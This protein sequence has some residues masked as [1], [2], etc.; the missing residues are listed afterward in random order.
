M[1]SVSSLRGKIMCAMDGQT[2][3]RFQVCVAAKHRKSHR[4]WLSPVANWQ[5]NTENLT[6]RR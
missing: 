6:V 5:L 2:S 3:T 4:A 1:D